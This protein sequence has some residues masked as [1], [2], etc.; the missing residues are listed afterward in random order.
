LFILS[1][2]GFFNATLSLVLPD[3]RDTLKYGRVLF[4]SWLSLP[5]PI[6]SY[7]RFSGYGI[8]FELTSAHVMNAD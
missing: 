3:C 2:G 1:E 8:F 7:D 4:M 5:F 6:T